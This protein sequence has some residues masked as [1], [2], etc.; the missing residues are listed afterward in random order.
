MTDLGV[1]LDQ[2][3]AERAK[4]D[5]ASC[6]GVLSYLPGYSVKVAANS[7]QLLHHLRLKFSTYCRKVNLPTCDDLFDLRA[8]LVIEAKPAFEHRRHARWR[9][10]WMMDR[11]LQPM[12]RTDDHQSRAARQPRAENQQAEQRR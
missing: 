1:V 3:K 7:F 11:V 10:L 5:R 2:L 6:C 9:V 4:L 8:L 12:N